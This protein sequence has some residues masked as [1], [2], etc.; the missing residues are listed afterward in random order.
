MSCTMAVQHEYTNCGSHF[1]LNST[2]CVL[3]RRRE[4][5]GVKL[6]VKEEKR[7]RVCTDIK[8]VTTTEAE[9]EDEIKADTAGE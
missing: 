6:K 2:A 7:K 4:S 8:E 1:V 3:W 5:N 9:G